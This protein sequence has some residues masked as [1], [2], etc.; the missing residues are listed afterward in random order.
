MVGWGGGGGRGQ[1]L[2]RVCPMSIN[3]NFSRE[4]RRTGGDSNRGPSAYQPGAPPL[5]V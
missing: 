3:H 5:D 1:S 2:E 4:R